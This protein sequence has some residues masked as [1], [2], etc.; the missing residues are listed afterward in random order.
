M[1]HG[2]WADEESKPVTGLGKTMG[3]ETRLHRR[4]Y[5]GGN[6]HGEPSRLLGRHRLAGCW[7]V[8][9]DLR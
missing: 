7:D 9:V 1:R 3:L 8:L 2:S 6:G 5:P 4:T